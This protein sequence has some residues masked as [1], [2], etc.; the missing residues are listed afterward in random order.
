VFHGAASIIQVLAGVFLCE[1][2]RHVY[3]HLVSSKIVMVAVLLC[4]LK[5]S[6]SDTLCHAGTVKQIHRF[7]QKNLHFAA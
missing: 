2:G 5:D 3:A 7:R 6:G 4:S 1:S